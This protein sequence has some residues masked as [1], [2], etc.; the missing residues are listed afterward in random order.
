MGSLGD[1][2]PYIAIGLG[3]KARGHEA[4]IATGACYRRKIEALGLGFRA[5]RPDC[6]WVEDPA[7]MR[8]FSHLRWGLVRVVR[9]WVLPALGD[10]Y[11]DTLEAAADADLIVSHPMTFAARLVAEKTGIPWA[12]TVHV[13]LGL[14]S[15]HDL[16][17]FS[18]AP[19]LFK[20][21]RFLGAG[22]W[23]PVLG[24]CKWATRSWAAPWDRVRAE[25]GLPPV[26]GGNPLADIHSPGLVLL[27][28]SGRLAGPQPDWPPGAAVT[29]FPI[30]D[31]DREPGL[32][33]ELAAFLDA[34][35]P[36]IVFTLGSALAAD[37][38]RFYE[39]SA[40]AARLLGRRAVLILMDARNR[41]P[42]LPD[43]VTACEYAPFSQLFPRAAAIVHHGGIGTTGLA[44]RSGRPM[45][46]MPCSW[47]QPDN[48]E[49][50]AR[51]G[52]ARVIPRRR[53]TPERAARELGRLLDDPRYARRA[54]EI[55]EEVRKEDGVGAACDALEA[56]LG[57]NRPPGVR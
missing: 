11:H 5:V 12:S 24:F 28:F 34:G 43:G 45:L 44:M 30:H 56:F 20:R 46:V 52:I 23:G 36:P 26:R 19:A 17:V 40:A 13:P 57:H 33:A 3:M 8:R 16:P 47:D 51:L 9:E 54:V 53:Y 18:Q 4:T 42:S 32:P 35:P 41:L 50:A 55:G 29:G 31:V 15:A 37:A 38:E 48:A 2:H 49:R 39:H 25:I 22:F 6:D 27:L 14:F 10:S 21:L 1:L 7:V